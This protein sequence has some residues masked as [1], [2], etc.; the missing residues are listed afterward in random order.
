VNLVSVY[1]PDAPRQ[2]TD[3]AFNSDNPSELWVVNRDGSVLIIEHPGEENATSIRRR[4]P[5]A[6]HFMDHP[7]ALAWG[8][9]SAMWGPTWGVCSDGN[10]GGD[11]FVGPSLMPG[12]LDIFAKPTPK[13]L[14]SHLDML[15]STA[16]CR[17]IAHV[18]ANIYWVFNSDKGSL[19]KYDFHK[20]HGPGNDD[21]SDGEIWRY[22]TGA[23]QGV[24][25]V[26]SHLFYDADDQYLYI[27]DTGNK[28]IAKLDTTKGTMGPSFPGSEDIQT[29]R[30]V[31]GAVVVDVVSTG[32]LSAPSG[33]EI[34][35]GLLFVSDNATSKFHVFDKMGKLIR[36]LD[37]GL[38]PQSLAGLA[39]G[40]DGKAYFTN[41]QDSRVYRIDPKF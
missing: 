8:T 5:A 31:N 11:Y 37:T 21:H 32:L 6:D 20:D 34:R 29:R 18:L 36:S 25:D 7:P 15:H 12:S 16:Y 26:P 3:L 41:L 39:F 35:G 17:G 2:P 4:D 13:G 30:M 1:E 9:D 23:V 38:P 19:D 40:Q 10:N 14:G 22:A 33:L 24:D 27:A 28:R